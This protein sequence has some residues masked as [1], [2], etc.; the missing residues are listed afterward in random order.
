MP[1][2]QFSP[3]LDCMK[4]VIWNFVKESKQKHLTKN[5]LKNEQFRIFVH[6]SL[7]KIRYRKIRSAIFYK[8][9]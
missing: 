5:E 2:S 8:Q 4:H 6:E 1:Q 7:T 9:N 3:N